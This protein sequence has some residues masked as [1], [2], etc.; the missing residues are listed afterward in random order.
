MSIPR[1]IHYCWFGGKPLPKS[2]KKCITSWGKFFPNYEIKQWDESNYDVFTNPY[3]QFC[4]NNKLWAYLSDFVR[5]D[6][7]EKFGGIYFDTDVEVIRYPQEL[8]TKGHAWFGWEPSKWIA[9]G[10]GFA[11]PSHHKALV[12]LKRIY[13]ERTTEELFRRFQKTKSLTGCPRMNTWQLLPYGLIQD[14]QY[15][16]ININGDCIIILPS[17]YMCPLD[18]VTGSLNITQN[19]FSIHWYTKSANGKWAYIRTRI[20]RPIHR[21]KCY[22]KTISHDNK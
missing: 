21:F 3:T 9:T 12:A 10:L 1:M 13:Q 18:D 11:A 20:S 16:C 7:V 6:V 14:G 2:A 5:L 22:L 15:Q 4:Y 19:T 17:D 8:I